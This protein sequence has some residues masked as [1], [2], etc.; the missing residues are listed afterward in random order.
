MAKSWQVFL[1]PGSSSP[2]QETTDVS[3]E[4]QLR[5]SGGFCI[6]IVITSIGQ[7]GGSVISS[8][9]KGPGFNPG[10]GWYVMM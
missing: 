3:E 8:K 4:L 10:P 9:Q 6:I 2:L 1:Y 7:Y 5:F